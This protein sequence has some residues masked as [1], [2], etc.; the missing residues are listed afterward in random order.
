MEEAFDLRIRE[1]ICYNDEWVDF[2]CESRVK[3]KETDYD[4]IFDKMADSNGSD[5][6]SCLTRYSQGIM[7]AGEVLEKLQEKKTGWDQYCFKTSK[8]RAYLKN[9]RAYTLNKESTGWQIYET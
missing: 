5:I 3:G 1:L 2:L 7:T 8:A 4:L 6:S 9:R